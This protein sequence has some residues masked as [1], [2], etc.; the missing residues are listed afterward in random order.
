[1][2]EL[3][4]NVTKLTSKAL[5]YYNKY[6]ITPNDSIS[7]EVVIR[8][9]YEQISIEKYDKGDG[10]YLLKLYCVSNTDN[11]NLSYVIKLR[12]TIR[13]FG[14]LTLKS[15]EINYTGYTFSLFLE[16]GDDNEFTIR[17]D[18]AKLYPIDSYDDFLYAVKYDIDKKIDLFNNKCIYNDSIYKYS[19]KSYIRVL[20]DMTGVKL[21]E[22][23]ETEMEKMIRELDILGATLI[24][25]MSHLIKYKDLRGDKAPIVLYP[26]PNDAEVFLKIDSVDS[27]NHNNIVDLIHANI[28][29]NNE[30]LE[31]RFTFYYYNYA[32][33]IDFSLVDINYTGLPDVVMIKTYSHD[34]GKR[35]C[36]Y[37]FEPFGNKD[38]IEKFEKLTES[39][40]KILTK[41]VDDARKSFEASIPELENQRKSKVV[42][43][44]DKYLG[45]DE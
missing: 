26:D 6:V 23:K 17:L 20:K 13:L 30:L 7:P 39:V 4:K 18:P 14:L 44:F 9:K 40:A 3:T 45:K 27:D 33:Y 25:C 28:R 31:V 19:I 32:A 41:M 42:T 29:I 24:N 11:L 22:E 10:E 12:Y 38:G 5:S 8:N 35:N 43:F 36:G 37:S 2:K 34:R 21:N 16:K 1:M 15:C